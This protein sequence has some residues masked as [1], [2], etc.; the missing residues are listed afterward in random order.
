[1]LTAAEGSK[2]KVFVL[3]VSFEN[4]GLFS[5]ICIGLLFGVMSGAVPGMFRVYSVYWNSIC[6]IV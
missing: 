5:V 2:G 1:M 4:I 3:Q 6:A